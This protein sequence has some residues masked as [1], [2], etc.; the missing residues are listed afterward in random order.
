MKKEK[1][2]ELEKEQ[3]IV[4]QVRDELYRLTRPELVEIA[5]EIDE[6]YPK[7]SSKYDTLKFILKNIEY[8]KKALEMYYKYKHKCFGCMQGFI[9]ETLG[10][11][12][13]KA[14]QLHRH[15]LIKCDYII[16]S[17][18]YRDTYYNAYNLK[19]VLDLVGEDI[20]NLL[21]EKKGVK[22]YDRN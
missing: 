11:T 13:Y 6:K 15:G 18:L 5:K 19:S 21:Q 17:R 2:T 12:P 20:D 16:T 7:S 14:K 10:V 1:L 8:D 4:K 9:C 3:I 22:K